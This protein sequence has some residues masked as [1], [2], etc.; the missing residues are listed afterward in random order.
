MASGAGR[1]SNDGRPRKMAGS[2]ISGRLAKVAAAGNVCRPEEVK[3]AGSCGRL[4]AMAGDGNG[5]N[6]RPGD[7]GRAGNEAGQH[8]FYIF[9][10]VAG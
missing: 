3:K 9:V 2:F 1:A 4:P 8:R 7:F 10:I 6:N 5:V